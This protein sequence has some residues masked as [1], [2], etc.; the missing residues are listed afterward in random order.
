MAITYDFRFPSCN[1]ACASSRCMC[2]AQQRVSW[3]SILLCVFSK[4]LSFKQFMSPYRFLCTEYDSPLW[5]Q[6]DR[7]HR[8]YYLTVLPYSAVPSR[9]TPSRMPHNIVSV[10]SSSQMCAIRLRQAARPA[11]VSYSNNRIHG[12]VHFSTADKCMR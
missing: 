9:V 1:V 12:I 11:V 2:K 7:N 5:E 6:G 3:Q 8:E 4:L 10:Q